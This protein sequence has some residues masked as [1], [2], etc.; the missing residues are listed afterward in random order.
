MDLTSIPWQGTRYPGV[1]IHFYAANRTTGRTLVLIQ[2]EPGY[3]YPRH[4]H[5]GEEQLL[6]VQ[7]GYRDE[8]GEHRAGEFARYANGTEHAPVAI[9]EPNAVPCVLL[10]LAH[11]GIKLL[12]GQT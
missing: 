11:E 7:G 5:R 10:A 1:S 12:G 3:G 4:A 2:M 8:S 9:S 6:V